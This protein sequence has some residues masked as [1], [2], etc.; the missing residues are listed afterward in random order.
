MNKSLFA[1]SLLGL[2]SASFSASAITSGE[3]G[4]VSQTTS[5]TNTTAMVTATPSTSVDAVA[6]IRP[7]VFSPKKIV[8]QVS[9]MGSAINT[10]QP[11]LDA[12]K[13]N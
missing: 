5:N 11:M 6:V 8:G 9:A 13:L 7:M 12:P 10:I 3:A 2:L 4:L 1:L